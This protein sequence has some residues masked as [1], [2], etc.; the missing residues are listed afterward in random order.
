MDP[1]GVNMKCLHVDFDMGWWS[2][3]GKLKELVRVLNNEPDWGS[4]VRDLHQA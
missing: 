1:T 2:R 4:A 3:S